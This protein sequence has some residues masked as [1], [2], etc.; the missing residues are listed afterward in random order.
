MLRKHV[1][2]LTCGMGPSKVV[3]LG[4]VKAL[5]SK[6]PKERK[7]DHRM[8]QPCIVEYESHGYVH[9]MVMFSGLT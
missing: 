9:P 1:R 7:K 3:A 6:R 5:L 4:V 8:L 2:L